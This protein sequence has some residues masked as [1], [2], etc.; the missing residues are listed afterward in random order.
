MV[1]PVKRRKELL[2]K[3]SNSFAFLIGIGDYQHIPKLHSPVNDVKAIAWV[4]KEQ[5]GFD[6]VGKM[7]NATST[8]IRQLMNWLKGETNLPTIAWQ[9]ETA[10]LPQKV[11][12]R[13]YVVFYFG[14]HGTNQEINEDKPPVGF[15]MPADAASNFEQY[16]KME[17]VYL[18]FSETGCRHFL[19]ILDCC[20]AGTIRFVATKRSPPTPFR[21]FIEKRFKK[22]LNKKARQVLVS[23]GPTQKA[24]DLPFELGDRNLNDVKQDLSEILGREGEKF[25]ERSYSPF[26]IAMIKAL[27]LGRSELKPPKNKTDG[28]IT[29]HELIIYL[30][31][32]VSKLTKNQMDQSP[33][34]FPIGSHEGG[35]FIFLDPTN[36]DNFANWNPKN[37]YKGLFAFEPEDHNLFHGRVAEVEAITTQLN[38]LSKNASPQLLF[39]TAPSAYGKSSLIKAGLFPALRK[40]KEH[41]E[42]KSLQLFYSR[43]GIDKNWTVYEPDGTGNAQNRYVQLGEH[44]DD[45]ILRLSHNPEQDGLFLID[46]FEEVLINK[47]RE[48]IEQFD[49]QV[50]RLLQDVPQRQITI[51]I[52]LRSDYEW[53]LKQTS[54]GQKFWKESHIYRLPPMALNQLREVIVKPATTNW[55]DFDAKLEDRILSE[56][57]GS[58]GA[59]PLLSFMMQSMYDASDKEER[60]FKVTTYEDELKGIHGTLSKKAD[61][62]L[63]VLSQKDTTHA[64]VMQKIFLRMVNLEDGGYSRRRVHYMEG[65]DSDDFHELKYGDKKEARVIKSVI[66]TLVDNQLV[67]Q[68]QDDQGLTFIEPAHDS[69]IR[70]WDTC[71]NWIAGFGEDQLLLQRKLWEAVVDY[72]SKPENKQ[73]NF[74]WNNNPSLDLLNAKLSIANHHFNQFEERF[75]QSSIQLREKKRRRFIMGLVGAVVVMAILASVALFQSAIAQ[76]QTRIAEAQRDSARIANN[77]ASLKTIEAQ[78]Q[79]DTAEIQKQFAEEQRDS[80]QLA[81]KL[82]IEKTKEAQQQRD[83]AEY[84]KNIAI[85]QKQLAERRAK[86]SFNNALTMRTFERN[87]TLALRMA[88]YNYLHNP[89]VSTTAT[90]FADI[91][92]DTTVLFQTTALKFTSQIMPGKI[93]C[94]PNGRDLLLLNKDEVQVWDYESKYQHTLKGPKSEII[95]LD[96]SPTGDSIVIGYKNQQIRLWSSTGNVLWDINPTASVIKDSIPQITTVAYS[97][98]RQLVAVA[99]ENAKILVAD[100]LGDTVLLIEA[101]SPWDSLARIKEIAFPKD[102]RQLMIF[103]DK[104]NAEM[105]GTF[106]FETKLLDISYAISSGP[107]QYHIKTLDRMGRFRMRSSTSYSGKRMGNTPNPPRHGIS[108]FTDESGFS[109][110]VRSPVMYMALSPTG[111]YVMVSYEDHSVEFFVYATE[112]SIRY[113]PAIE[114]TKSVRISPDWEF[115]I[116]QLEDRIAIYPLGQ[117]LFRNTPAPLVSMCTSLNNMACSTDSRYV[118]GDLTNC[119]NNYVYYSDPPLVVFDYEQLTIFKNTA[120]ELDSFF[121][122]HTWHWYDNGVFQS[123]NGSKQNLGSTSQSLNGHYSLRMSLDNAILLDDRTNVRIQIL[124]QPGINH[125][126]FSNNQQYMTTSSMHSDK[127]YNSTKIWKTPWARLKEDIAVYTIEEMK[128]YGIKT[129]N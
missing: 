7:I 98:D 77:L 55:F 112:K 81:K 46:Q 5:Q 71:R 119:R 74:L 97:K 113:F 44:V 92:N 108:V 86:V 52:T 49:Q 58:P 70:H 43:P 95:D 106:D 75:I 14:G 26:A 123:L 31:E 104:P 32:Q 94:S 90:I 51:V 23:A 109:K 115:L 25:T 87:P 30:K 110:D 120:S 21:P 40:I 10:A 45:V 36:P 96:F 62:V 38:T 41:G 65:I 19:M 82:A 48:E 91:Y 22:F 35:D 57:R 42:N 78:E 60:V 27:T 64:L 28:I 33:E 15:L 126:L 83:S 129:F 76:E 47:S 6:Y 59:L 56:V 4:L 8:E 37:P 88:E 39:V 3:E 105:S 127:G 72:Q 61:D 68:G 13:D 11:T 12:E 99:Y 116:R 93:I 122:S 103:Y 102:N 24:A 17:D 128:K 79:R 73:S 117:K 114:G 85:V 118:M 29:P 54:L 111:E 63:K 18:A 121:A 2:E 67:V 69:L 84:Q 66:N 101:T 9:G 16:I 1:S 20:F 100:N 34:Y 107:V 124:P 89:D 125:V 53:R 50:Y 80:A